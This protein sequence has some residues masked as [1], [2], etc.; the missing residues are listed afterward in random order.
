MSLFQNQLFLEWNV[1]LSKHCYNE[2]YYVTNPWNGGAFIA[3]TLSL[4]M[5]N[6]AAL[7]NAK[8]PK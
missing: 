2:C 8:F 7:A 4:T 3:F 1:H 6:Q 5:Q